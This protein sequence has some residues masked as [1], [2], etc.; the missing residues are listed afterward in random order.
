MFFVTAENQS[1]AGT[2]KIIRMVKRRVIVLRTRD[3]IQYKHT[4][5][6]YMNVTVLSQHTVPNIIKFKQNT[7]F[8]KNL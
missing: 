5:K 8:N 3:V 7:F 6:G 2:A 1:P 4:Q